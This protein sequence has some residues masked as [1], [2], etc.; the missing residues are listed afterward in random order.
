MRLLIISLLLVCAAVADDFTTLDGT[1]YTGKIKRI[2]P[3]GIV[4]ETDAG[5]EKIAFADLPKAIQ[6]QYHYDPAKAQDYAARQA[7]ARNALAAHT[8]AVQ[9]V[10]AQKVTAEANRETAEAQA[11]AAIAAQT[12][13]AAQAAQASTSDAQLQPTGDGKQYIIYGEVIQRTRKGLLV[14]A[15]RR[16]GIISS[17]AQVEG[18]VWLTGIDAQEGATIKTSAVSAGT[19]DY[20]TV[21]GAAR[22]VDAYIAQ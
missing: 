4:L 2:E 9:A 1:K 21:L 13:A 15:E 12:A 17:N 7:A 11:N 8:A 16:E 22:T 10:N 14:S 5:I 6:A 19:Y 3:D 18:D 20:T